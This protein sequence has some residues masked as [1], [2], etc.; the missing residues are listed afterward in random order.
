MKKTM[1]LLIAL[2]TVAFLA[3]SAFSWGHGS[4]KRGGCTKGWSAIAN[5]TDAQQSQLREL[6][7][8]FI[9]DT[10]ETRSAMMIK[11]QEVRMLLQTSAPERA[12]LM[13]LAD[14]I[15]ALQKTMSE[16]RI[17]MALAAKKIAPELNL[18][19]FGRHGR[20]GYGSGGGACPGGGYGKGNWDSCPYAGQ[21]Q[22][23]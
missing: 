19:A 1:I 3:T 18:S 22:V 5:L 23:E 4:G 13:S 6:R 16:K 20:Y 7:Q 14:E 2:L 9:D 12:K 8:A 10:Y 15:M 21:S 17:D 11:H